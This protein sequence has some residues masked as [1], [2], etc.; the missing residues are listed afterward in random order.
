MYEHHAV[1]P[2]SF[3]PKEGSKVRP[4]AWNC[5]DS[6]ETSSVGERSSENAIGLLAAPEVVAIRSLVPG[7]VG[8]VPSR[9]SFVSKLLWPPSLPMASAILP[10]VR[11]D[12]TVL[13]YQYLIIS[14]LCRSTSLL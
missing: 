1:L 10:H 14:D 3:C 2:I 4:F 5:W 7:P 9:R 11:S 8:V 6:Q 13:R 12:S